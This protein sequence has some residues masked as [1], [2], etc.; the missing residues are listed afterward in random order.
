[1]IEIARQNPRDTFIDIILSE[2][3][4]K[5]HS[6]VKLREC[7]FDDAKSTNRLPF[8]HLARRTQPKILKSARDSL[9]FKLARDCFLLSKF[10]LGGPISEVMET[11]SKSSSTS[12]SSSLPRE[13]NTTLS[14]SCQS[15]PMVSIED[16]VNALRA[17]IVHLKQEHVERQIMYEKIEDLSKRMSALEMNSKSHI[18]NNKTVVHD[19]KC[20]KEQVSNLSTN[21]DK[22]ENL[23]TGIH[24]D[25][26]SVKELI[27]KNRSTANSVKQSIL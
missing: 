5:A 20:L 7:L 3:G 8:G 12:R 6:L 14:Q 17:D 18:Q 24:K 26:K 23:A 27:N 11:I 16:T 4:D 13:K 1:M 25:L 9:E 21:H 10:I 19:T 22:L 2:F 15:L